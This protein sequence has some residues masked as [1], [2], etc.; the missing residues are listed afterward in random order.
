MLE[1]HTAHAGTGTIMGVNVKKE[2]ATQ[3]GCIVTNPETNQMVHYVEK[4]EG[5]ISNI[6]NGGVYLFDKSLFD[7]IK[8]AMDEKTAR[9]A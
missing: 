1:L 9:A 6:V 7:V 3:Y 4:P 2:T 8:V 5:W